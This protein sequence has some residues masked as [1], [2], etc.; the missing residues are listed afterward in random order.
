MFIFIIGRLS[1][2]DMQNEYWLNWTI[3]RGIKVKVNKS[4][5][6]FQCLNTDDLND[7]YIGLGKPIENYLHM[8]V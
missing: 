1:N 7:G 6:R 3:I 5:P 2:F 4:N 8:S